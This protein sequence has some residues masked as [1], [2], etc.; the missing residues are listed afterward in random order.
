MQEE[1]MGVRGDFVEQIVA[2]SGSFLNTAV[3]FAN[4]RGG[5]IIFY[6]EGGRGFSTEL[7]I[8]PY[9]DE[10]TRQI[11]ESCEPRIFPRVGVELQDGRQVVVVEIF[12][13]M[14]KPYFLKEAGMMDG[15]Y[16]R[17]GGATRLAEPYQVQE[18]LLSG[19]NS[20]ADQLAAQTLVD[21]VEIEEFCRMMY[22]EAKKRRTDGEDVVRLQ[23]E[24]LLSWKLLREEEGECRATHGW[25]LLAGTA[26][27]LFPE[28]FVQCAEYLG[29]TRLDFVGGE[30]FFGSLMEQVDGAAS[31]VQER[32]ASRGVKAR[33]LSDLPQDLVHRLIARAVCQRNY[34]APGRISL[35]LYEDRLEITVPGLL[36]ED[37][38]IWKLKTG[39]AKIRN[40]A[41]AAAFCYMGMMSGFQSILPELYRAA[42]QA[43]LPEPA[44]ITLGDSVRIN[45]YCRAEEDVQ[46]E[47]V[48]AEETVSV[49][50]DGSAGT[51]EPAE[52][53]ALLETAM[54]AEESE[55]IDE[56]G[57]VETS[58][59]AEEAAPVEESGLAGE[60][61]AVEEA[62]REEIAP[63]EETV[64]V[65]D[66]APAE[67]AMSIEE[68]A[69]VEEIAP[70]EEA[71]PTEE[72]APVET[73]ALIGEIV[74]TEEA[75]SVEE[76]V[77]TEE[78]VPVEEE[79]P[80]E[81]AVPAEEEV[82]TEEAVSAEEAV[83]TEEAV[84]EEAVASVEDALPEDAAPVETAEP[85]EE[86]ASAEEAV[87]VEATAPAE[88]AELKEGAAEKADSAENA[89]LPEEAK[90]VEEAASVEEVVPAE[91]TGTAEKGLP[92]DGSPLP[93][94]VVEAEPAEEDRQETEHDEAMEVDS[95][96][97][98][99]L[100]LAPELKLEIES[101]ADLKADAPALEEEPA[102]PCEEKTNAAQ[103]ELSFAAEEPAEKVSEGAAEGSLE[104]KLLGMI[105]ENPKVTQKALKEAL[106]IS[107]ATV[108]RMTTALH[109]AGVIERTGTN[110]SGAWRILKD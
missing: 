9:I 38:T 1:M 46:P 4:G 58:G 106:G 36:E 85:I 77:P 61:M 20:S 55:S 90:T 24:E 35:V 37:M 47:I 52:E 110:R 18:L 89:E 73:A 22:S 53:A 91:T 43:H 65:E 57:S 29:S 27:E 109:K 42:K 84:P 108:K 66:A 87:L 63:A 96:H 59:W 99:D 78:A 16:V 3:A 72:A 105:R 10:V 7:E 71:I 67:E 44:V 94:D 2:E 64:P 5:R 49:E 60:A 23:K 75:A 70:V 80:T 54:P 98:M 33:G 21:E 83:S 11:F 104:E 25:H 56:A 30:E 95:E 45:L 92:I 81:E 15:T 14:E 68:A 34:A 48:A 82:S 19:T 8:I 51:S 86:I 26:D 31:Y 41:I 88:T 28:G 103:Q 76:A 107:I 6:G 102:E 32:L 12:P 100:D 13:G 50:E 62:K 40:R 69:S 74:P 39:F 79:A 93:E 101:L 17:V 97:E